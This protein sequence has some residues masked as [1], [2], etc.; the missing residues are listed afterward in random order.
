MFML[1]III[2]DVEECGILIK[3]CFNDVFFFFI[4]KSSISVKLYI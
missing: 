1:K 3:F 2:D 4:Y